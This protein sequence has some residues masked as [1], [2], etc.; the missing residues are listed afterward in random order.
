LL[1][2]TEE[3]D[4]EEEGTALNPSA[5]SSSAEEPDRQN[6]LPLSSP[7]TDTTTQDE[8]GGEEAL[9]PYASLARMSMDDWGLASRGGQ[10]GIGEGTGYEMDTTGQPRQVR[11]GGKEVDDLLL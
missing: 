3:S 8:N 10:G 2:E 1:G 9:D 6:S 4:E 7:S 11:G 5:L